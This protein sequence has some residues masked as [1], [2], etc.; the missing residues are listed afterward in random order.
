ME[1]CAFC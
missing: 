1:N